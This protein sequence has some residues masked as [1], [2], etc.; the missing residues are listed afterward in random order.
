MSHRGRDQSK[1]T[2]PRYLQR[3]G[4]W[5]LLFAIVGTLTSVFAWSGMQA[6]AQ[7]LPN[8]T[9]NDVTL[10]EG[11]ASTTSFTFTVALSAPAGPSGVTFDIATADG[12]AT[13]PSDYTSKS[14]TSQ[15]IPAGSSTYS[16]TMLVNGDSTPET[17]ETFFVNVTNVTG[18]NVTDGQGQGTIVNDDTSA[19]LSITKTDGVTT[20][21]PGGSV[22]YTITASNAGPNAAVGARVADTFPA[23]LTATWTCVGAG[24]GTCTASGSDNI[25]DTVNLPAGASVTYT[26]SASISASATGSLS[27][28]AT[29][30][31]PSGVTDPTPGNN[32]AT[33]TDTL[34]PQADLAITKTDGV[35][36]AVPGGSVTYTITASNAGPS[37]APGAT[38]TD[39]FPAA[40]TVTWTCVGAGGGT[41][42]ASGSGNIGDTVN[43]PSGGS[44]T[45]T[46][47]ANVSASATGSLSNTATV[48]APSGITDPT[49]GNNSAT[50]TDTIPTSTPTPTATPSATPTQP[51]TSTPTPSP[52]ATP[53]QSQSPTLTQMPTLTATPTPTAAPSQTPPSANSTATQTPMPTAIPTPTG[54]PAPIQVRALA[55]TPTLTST[56]P[57]TA[58]A[59]AAAAPSSGGSPPRPPT[60]TPTPP[61]DCGQTGRQEEFAPPGYASNPGGAQGQNH[62][63]YNTGLT[64]LAEREAFRSSLPGGTDMAVVNDA[65]ARGC[66][67]AWIR[68]HLGG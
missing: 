26:A 42:T 53:T 29:V 28:T 16:F 36:T 14:L 61:P 9:I 11:N 10:N 6:M 39:V 48:S 38:V 22:T 5:R 17:N 20:A 32:S 51:P 63:V 1:R 35:T 44:V 41:C 23:T 55:A 25:N 49:P 34:S 30:S 54:T 62:P 33:D 52:T 15:T 47:S 65:I 68:S 60:P 64:T 18:A 27:N 67:P 13:A 12:T 24:G 37:N 56:P 46:A 31:A 4:R 58:Q 19:D 66:S 21:V 40:L 45:Y 3:A 50:D 7:P 59:S 8:L 57:P 2:L 43:L